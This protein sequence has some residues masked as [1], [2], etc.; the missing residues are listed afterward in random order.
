MAGFLDS[1][2]GL[3]RGDTAATADN[4]KLLPGGVSSFWQ[5]FT[6][7]PKDNP[8]TPYPG[9]HPSNVHTTADAAETGAAAGKA[10]HSFWSTQTGNTVGSLLSTLALG[11]LGAGIGAIASPGARGLGA[12]RGFGVGAVKG[13]D[14][15]IALRKSAAQEPQNLLDAQLKESQQKIS[16]D[17]SQPQA[18]R[19]Y[20]QAASMD[21]T[22]K[23]KFPNV[24]D[25]LE[26][27]R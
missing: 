5:L 7:V 4:P 13:I 12:A 27:K 10:Q 22:F 8:D 2:T 20:L 26:Y 3:N 21:P 18:I 25:Y 19:E 17:Q 16:A 23:Q 9:G 11:G 1:L 6:G 14:Q 15:D 24:G